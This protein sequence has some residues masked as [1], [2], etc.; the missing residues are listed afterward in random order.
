MAD[1]IETLEDVLSE[2]NE[3]DHERDHEGDT[4]Y[5]ASELPY[6]FGEED[7][8]EA[9]EDFRGFLLAT[10]RGI[11]VGTRDEVPEQDESVVVNIGNQRAQ[12]AG[13]LESLINRDLSG[14]GR[15]GILQTIAQSLVTINEQLTIQNETLLNILANEQIISRSVEPFNA[16]TVSGTNAIDN[17]DA[18]QEVVPESETTDIPTRALF[19]KA[20]SDNQAKI[21]FGDDN[22]EPTDG[23]ILEK[24]QFI[25][26]EMD[27]RETTLYMASQSSGPVVEILGVV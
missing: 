20:S 18:P 17:A 23:F 14:I 5:G 2:E 12:L 21:A 26:L 25:F 7:L 4:Q 24:G 9:A 22:I 27:L 15:L 8:K 6:E 13:D 3:K 11:N 10:P 19:I 1:E 16:I